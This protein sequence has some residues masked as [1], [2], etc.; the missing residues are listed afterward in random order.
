MHRAWPVCGV[1]AWRRRSLNL[2]GYHWGTMHAY[3]PPAAGGPL[4]SGHWLDDARSLS[5]LAYEQNGWTK[6]GRVTKTGAMAL[7]DQSWSDPPNAVWPQLWQRRQDALRARGWLLEGGRLTR[8][9]Q[10][11]IHSGQWKSPPSAVMQ[12]LLARQQAACD[13][14]VRQCKARRLA[15]ED[16][17]RMPPPPP[18]SSVTPVE[19]FIGRHGHHPSVR[20]PDPT[21]QRNDI[22]AQVRDI[23]ARFAF[24]DA[25]MGIL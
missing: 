18:R 8:A 4:S 9:G 16:R 3:A 24:A 19:A 10:A 17:V 12:Q 2:R 25:G 15:A 14:L 22:R 21:L 23:E 13:A 11:A 7:M 1:A 20:A 5:A 6:N